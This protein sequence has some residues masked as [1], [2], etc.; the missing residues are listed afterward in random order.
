MVGR[1]TSSAASTIAK[2]STPVR[3]PSFRRRRVRHHE[4]PHR[5]QA[6]L[7]GQAEVLHGDVGL[8][9][10]GGDPAHGGAVVGRGEDV[11]LHA[12]AGQHEKSDP[13]RACARHG[14]LDELLFRG[15]AEAVRERRATESVSV[16]HLDHRYPG[17]V[18]RRDDGLDLRGGE[19]VALGVRAV[20]Q[21]GV[22][23]PHV[24]VGGEGA[25]QHG[26]S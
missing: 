25:G 8:G 21:R 16:R 26:N 4:E 13:G 14:D 11:V 15:V 2:K 5:L 22:G 9:A 3:I 1:T 19:L 6:A 20:A 24:E 18:E 7:A 12:D 17:G 10:V 23:D